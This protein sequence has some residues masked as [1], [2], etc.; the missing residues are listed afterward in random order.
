ML[1]QIGELAPTSIKRRV[2]RMLAYAGMRMDTRE[3]IG[4]VVMTAV[5]FSVL[6]YLV[7]SNFSPFPDY[8]VYPLVGLVFILIVSMLFTILYLQVEDRRMVAER[9]LPDLLQL[10]ASNIKSGVTPIVALRMATR[11]EFG[12][13]HQEILYVTNK[14]LGTESFVDALCEI[15]G[16]I[17]SEMLNRTLLLFASSLKSGGSVS[18]VLETSAEDIRENQELRRELI[19]G[20]NM[21]VV[22]ILFTVVIA[23]PALL[24]LSIQFVD[25]VSELHGPDSFLSKQL[26][27]SMSLPISQDFIFNVSVVTLLAT[28]IFASLMIGVI[29]HGDEMNG[30]R[31][32]PLIL[33]F[34]LVFFY[35][36]KT[37]LVSFILG[38]F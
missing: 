31:Y 36:S 32:A 11:P 18:R 14:S 21:Y 35:V 24:S 29:H 28:S 1:S 10:T 20:T 33:S 9:A 17:K 13:L 3:W 27:L 6:S 15:S 25:M 2:G 34:S 16:R 26:G 8:F 4:L 12:P 19:A 5:S 22:F 37:Y 7:L 23:M 38:T 30:L